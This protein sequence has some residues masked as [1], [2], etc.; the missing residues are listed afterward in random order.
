MHVDS[1]RKGKILE[2]IFRS[3][4]LLSPKKT[5]WTRNRNQF[6]MYT[7]SAT[8]WNVRSVHSII[9]PNKVAFSISTTGFPRFVTTPRTLAT[10]LF[11]VRQ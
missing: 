10:K 8:V 11:C 7:H 5:T 9:H 6:D 2:L 1:P 3:Y 4:R